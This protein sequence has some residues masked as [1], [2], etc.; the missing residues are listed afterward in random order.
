M[1]KDKSATQ[2]ALVSFKSGLGF[3][4]RVMTIVFILA[5]AGVVGVSYTMGILDTMMGTSSSDDRS[6]E[7]NV[8]A[9]PQY[10]SDDSYNNLPTT[11]FSY[12]AVV[13]A[14]SSG[15]RAHVYRYGKLGSLKGALYISPKHD[16]MK[17]KPGLSSFAENP[18]AAGTSLQGLVDFLKEKVPA[19]QL[20]TTPIWLKATAGLRMLD[21]EHSEPILESVRDFLESS[22]FMFKREWASIISGKEEGANGWLAYNYMLRIV[23]PKERRDPAVVKASNTAPNVQQAYAVVEMGGASSQV[24]QRSLPGVEIPSEYRFAFE[25]D[26]EK[27]VLYTHS[28]LGYGGEQGREALNS[29]LSVEATAGAEPEPLN[30]PCLNNGLVISRNKDK[31]ARSSVYEGPSWEQLGAGHS[32]LTLKGV[33]GGIGDV[34]RYA[35]D[36]SAC[37]RKIKS[38]FERTPVNQCKSPQPVTFD[39]VHQPDWVGESKNFMVFENFYYAASAGAVPSLATDKWVN[40]REMMNDEALVAPI[41]PL[42]TSPIMYRHAARRVCKKEWNELGEKFPVDS[43][44]KDVNTKLCFALSFASD[45]LI[46]GLHLSPG[47]E[48]T[49]AKDVNGSDIEWAL[50]AAYMESAALLKKNAL[51]G[52]GFLNRESLPFLHSSDGTGSDSENIFTSHNINIS[53]IIISLIVFFAVFNAIKCCLKRSGN[54]SQMGTMQDKAP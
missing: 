24:T 46:E 29:L 12:L 1:G 53:V 35:Q 8:K 36:G 23:G 37:L 15:C 31:D 25:I 28:Y 40:R 48:I 27:Y 17:V 2:M 30:D 34:S 21:K 26:G 54:Q 10:V 49:V 44:P 16:S 42:V 51:R 45:F 22:P 6:M 43:Q 18:S 4:L 41:F 20:S 52:G 47:R 9:L 39:C 38:V 50:G 5:A 7:L 11:A 32:S 14:G 33:A 19:D 13:D 3:C